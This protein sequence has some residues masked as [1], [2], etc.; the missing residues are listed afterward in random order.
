MKKR[1][2]TVVRQKEKRIWHAYGL[3]GLRDERFAYVAN[4]ILSGRF[5][6]LGIRP[7]VRMQDSQLA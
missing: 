1:Q 3:Q 6:L 2:V 5:T 4:Q 7:Q